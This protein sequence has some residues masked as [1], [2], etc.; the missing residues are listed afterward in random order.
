M[1]GKFTFEAEARKLP[2]PRHSDEV[3]AAWTDGLAI[4][5]EYI[6]NVPMAYRLVV[7]RRYRVTVEEIEEAK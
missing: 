1:A 6:K 4:Q 2:K 3:V 5:S 7:G